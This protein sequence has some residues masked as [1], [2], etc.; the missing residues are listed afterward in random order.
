[1]INTGMVTVT[2]AGTVPVGGAVT[3]MDTVTDTVTDAVTGTG[4]GYGNQVLVAP[5][6]WSTAPKNGTAHAQQFQK[7]F[8]NT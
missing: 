4:Y 8:N 7:M 1:M 2:V 6:T 3:V 5:P